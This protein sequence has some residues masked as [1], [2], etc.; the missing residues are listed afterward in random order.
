MTL[1]RAAGT[2]FAALC[3]EHFFLL[4]SLSFVISSEIGALEELQAFAIILHSTK[5]QL[6]ESD[7]LPGIQEDKEGPSR[8]KPRTQLCDPL[9]P[10]RVAQ[11]PPTPQDT[12]INPN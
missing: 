7:G 5:T 4:F 8:R 1:I 10:Q 2:A 12:A 3:P 6:L 11:A 9:V